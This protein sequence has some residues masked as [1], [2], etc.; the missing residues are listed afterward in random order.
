[1]SLPAGFTQ[2]EY[3]ESSGTQ[4]IDTGVSIPHATARVLV[5]FEVTSIPTSSQGV[6]TITGHANKGFSWDTNFL[7]LY[8]QAFFSVCK[9]DTSGTVTVGSRY[10]FDYSSKGYS[11]NGGEF[12]P[13]SATYTD[14]YNDT[15][16][17]SS[18]KYG[19]YKLFAYQLYDGTDLSRN[20][21]PCKDDSDTIGLFDLVGGVFYKN[22]GTGVFIAGPEIITDTEAPDAP[23]GLTVLEQDE[24]TAVL[25]WN[26]VEP[27][28]GYRV[29]RNGVWMQDTTATQVRI[30]VGLFSAVDFA[31]SAYIGDQEGE[32]SSLRVAFLPVSDLLPYLIFI[33]TREDVAAGNA[34]GTYNANDINR[35]S[36]ACNYIRG[37]FASYGYA[38]PDALR[39]DWAEND[40][41][42]AGEMAQYIRTIRALSDIVVYMPRVP[43]LPFSMAK[44]GFISANN[45]EEA[46]YHLGR[47]A[48]NIPATWYE[49]GQIESGVAYT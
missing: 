42:T 12:I 24:E 2:L 43:D 29:Y 22:A 20:M 48:E 18:G 21:I 15:I 27:S 19:S 8:Y 16:F 26:P 32:K 3:I 30:S 25:S 46:L 28:D 7:Y 36:E 49:C 4:Y 34:L 23:E 35:V 5:D 33:R 1:M 17:Y 31:V 40:L 37:L 10:V 13:A 41:P 39:V 14:G 38:V 9:K 11:V 6:Y 47:I 44:F 45:I